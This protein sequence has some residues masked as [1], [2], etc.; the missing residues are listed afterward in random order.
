MT[1]S[2]LAERLQ[3]V[4]D[5]IASAARSVGRSELDVTLVA[6]SKKQRPVDMN[7]LGT[8]I[9]NSGRT[10]VFGESYLQ[11]FSAKKEE[12]RVPHQ[13][14]Y[15]APLQSNKIPKVVGLFTLIESI[16]SEKVLR[17]VEAESLK[18]N[19]QLP[20]FIQV[21]VSE[22]PRKSGVSLSDCERIFAEIVPN[23]QAVS[24]RGLMTIT[25]YYE[26]PNMARADFAK[27][28][29]LGQ[30]LQLSLG[31]PLALSMGMSADFDIAIQEGATHVRVGSAL[32]GDRQ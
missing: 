17:L 21:N 3:L 32:F 30:K 5:R 6:V 12:L 27:L 20:V 15:I 22:D 29:E 9:L 25:E 19:I 18:Q 2:G 14:H 23:L 7:E 28:R 11:E 24:V 8:L 4:L 13:V 16:H 10:V 26:V 1:D 31:R